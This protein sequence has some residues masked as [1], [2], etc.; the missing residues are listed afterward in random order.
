[1]RAVGHGGLQ[2]SAFIS[3]RY[4]AVSGRNLGDCSTCLYSVF[5]TH[6]F[7]IGTSINSSYCWAGRPHSAQF[8]SNPYRKLHSD[9][10]RCSMRRAHTIV[11][12]YMRG[13]G[14]CNHHPSNTAFVLYLIFV[15]YCRYTSTGCEWQR[16]RCQFTICRPTPRPRSQR[17][18]VSTPLGI[19]TK[20]IHTKFSTYRGFPLKPAVSPLLLFASLP[21]CNQNQAAVSD[22]LHLLS[23]F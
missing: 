11:D 22:T 19:M 18:R 5:Y 2:P 17:T 15:L 7:E 21:D 8:V 10:E 13:Y 9:W 12:T 1:M 6:R 23:D 20:G 16:Q 14:I 4:L 3:S